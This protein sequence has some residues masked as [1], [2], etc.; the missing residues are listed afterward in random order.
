M[1]YQKIDEKDAILQLVAA[2]PGG[3][4]K[5]VDSIQRIAYLLEEAGV[6]NGFNFHWQ[7]ASPYCEKI[8]KITNSAKSY[9]KELK[10]I[11]TKTKSG[12]RD[13]MYKT[14]VP[15][16]GCGDEFDYFQ[17]IVTQAARYEPKQLDLAVSAAFY[18][19]YLQKNRDDTWEW[20]KLRKYGKWYVDLVEE[21]QKVYEELRST[22]GL[23]KL[24]EIPIPNIFEGE[25]SK[26]YGY[27]LICG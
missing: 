6:V 21:S 14:F 11:H 2:A 1:I 10:I 8:E 7:E 5:G 17:I 12:V 22:P 18:Q 3:A 16:H 4:I 27:S 26:N 9:F 20:V 23:E 24:P 13:I 19:K 15:Y 25:N